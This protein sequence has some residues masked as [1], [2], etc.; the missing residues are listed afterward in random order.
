MMDYDDDFLF[1]ED[2]IL[3]HTI[4]S[5]N[6]PA[7]SSKPVEGAKLIDISD[8]QTT[9]PLANVELHHMNMMEDRIPNVEMIKEDHSTADFQ[10]H[11]DQMGMTITSGNVVIEK[12]SSNLIGISIGGGAPLCPCLYI[13]QVFDNTPAAQ[14]GVLEAGDELVAVNSECLKG[15]TKVEVAKMIQACDK[16]VSIIYN[17]LHADVRQGKSLDIVLKKV[18]HRLVESMGSATADALGLSRAILC[19]D[20]LV[21]KLS[22][23]EKTEN[24]YKGLVTHAKS[25][26]HAFFDLFQIYKIFGDAFASMGV[27]EPQPRASEAFTKFAEQHRQMEKLGID[28][29]KTI[30]PVLS[31]LETYLIKAIPDTRMTI[32]K[33]ADAKFEYLSYCLK[34]KEMDDE[35]QSYIAIQEPLYRV[36]TGNYEYRLILRCRQNARSKFAKLRADVLV[37]LELLDN[38]HVEHVVTQLQKFANGLSEYYKNVSKLLIENNNLFPVEIDL[39]QN[40]FQYKPPGQLTPYTD[41]EEEEGACGFD[42]SKIL[43]FDVAEEA[44]SISDLWEKPEPNEASESKSSEVK[45]RSDLSDLVDLSGFTDMNEKFNQMFLAED[46]REAKQP[47]F[48]KGKES[49]IASDKKD[50]NESLLLIEDKKESDENLFFPLL[51][52]N[53]SEKSDGAFGS[54]IE[55]KNASESLSFLDTLDEQ[56]INIGT[57]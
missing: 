22:G 55:S 7:D 51:D 52:I 38:K 3:M 6:N 54:S 37:K 57:N 5:L 14:D 23:L 12:D 43:D 28:M 24:L 18:K 2:K 10:Q 29:L 30:K 49:S 1:E 34:V 11:I 40:A 41:D 4:S 27:K 16:K 36:E 50:K 32:S 48:E 46:R 42:P 33:Y 26:L 13:V 31:D 39:A 45:K 19:N 53:S 15:K 56:L 25:V 44:S 9:L 8:F 47:Q 35:E 20:T 17:K 21:Q